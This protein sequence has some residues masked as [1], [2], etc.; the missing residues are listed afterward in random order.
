M[1]KKKSQNESGFTRLLG[2]TVL[3]SLVFSAGMITGQRLLRHDAMPPLVSL[4]SEAQASQE[5]QATAPRTPLK[6][7]FSFYEHLARTPEDEGD[8]DTPADTID[9]ERVEAEPVQEEPEQGQATESSEEVAHELETPETEPSA[10]K[11]TPEPD[12][13]VAVDAPE[14][15]QETDAAEVAAKDD[16]EVERAADPTPK[17]LAARVVEAFES[18]QGAETTTDES[19]PTHTIQ[20]GNHSSKAAAVRELSR[21]RAMKIDAH[22]IT[23]EVG[24]R[25]LYRVRVG[26]FATDEAA[27]ADLDELGARDITG[28]VVPL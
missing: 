19:V 7:T 17:S 9:Q 1:T 26:K 10:V 13:E 11:E 16:S 4:S 15:Q 14:V 28:M 12:E 23:V 27:R 18:D 3:L 2:W 8:G 5:L 20:V 25:R 22:M 24:D 6:T 21:L